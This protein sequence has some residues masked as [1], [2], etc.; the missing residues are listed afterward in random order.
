MG[1]LFSLGLVAI[2]GVIV[3]AFTFIALKALKFT[4]KRAVLVAFAFCIG[5]GF[6]AATFVVLG[7][8]IL[9]PEATFETSTQV[10]TYLGSMAG[11]ALCVAL[12]VARVVAM[13]SN[14]SLERTREG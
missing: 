5:G 12:L 10:A 3:V 2:F 4:T 7:R 13:R 8:F 9:G 6:G 11:V 14:T 1:P